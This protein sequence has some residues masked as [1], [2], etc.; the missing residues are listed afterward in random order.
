MK[1]AQRIL[2]M[3]FALC[4]LMSMASA[5]TTPADPLAIVSYDRAA[6]PDWA[7]GYGLTTPGVLLE[8]T[9]PEAM[10]S[11]TA[12][13]P[14]GLTPSQYLSQRLDLAGETLTV[15]DA[16]LSKW[17]GQD[18]GEE[19][20]LSYSYTYPDGDE[21]HFLRSWSGRFG[22]L[23]I[24]LTVDAW[25]EEAHQLIDAAISVFV[26]GGF[27]MTVTQNAAE[28]TATLSDV[29]A[30]D[31]GLIYLQLTEAGQEF[32]RSDA[33][34][35]LSQSAVILFPNPDDPLL[36]T[37]VDPDYASLANA[38]LLYEETSDSPAQFYTLIE[39]NQI[40]YMEYDLMQ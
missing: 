5:Q 8:L 12:L 14:N 1:N 26:D 23:L 15:S 31:N 20:L 2:S 39:N 22:D 28:L 34:Y 38:I 3:I 30:A 6:L 17:E 32:S 13:E 24:D 36:L 29:V 4:L 35:P 21:V 25:G 37:P 7:P 18:G 40:L 19:S 16:Q 9:H 11:V 10:L 33:Y 27:T